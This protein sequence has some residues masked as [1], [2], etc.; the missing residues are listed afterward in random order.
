MFS[1]IINKFKNNNKNLVLI[2]VTTILIAILALCVY[3]SP[4]FIHKQ[5]IMA[6]A[7]IK[8]DNAMFTSKALEEFASNSKAKPSEI[9]QKVAQELNL[10][11]KNPYNKKAPAY[12]FDTQCNGCNRIEC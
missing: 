2:E 7:K 4:K 1:N 9:A 3:F 5:E 10:I 11:A 6:A 12:S 8:A